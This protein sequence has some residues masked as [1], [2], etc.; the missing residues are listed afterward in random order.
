MMDELRLDL[1]ERVP[2]LGTQTQF[3]SKEGCKRGGALSMTR[4]Q[5]CGWGLLEIGVHL[6]GQK[7]V[8]R[9]A[10]VQRA[11]V[12][13]GAH[14]E[15]RPNGFSSVDRIE[16]GFRRDDG[17]GV[18]DS[19]L[20]AR[21]AFERSFKEGGPIPCLEATAVLTVTLTTAPV[22]V[23]HIGSGRGAPTLGQRWRNRVGC[24]TFRG[25]PRAVTR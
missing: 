20:V 13:G 2:S 21:Q 7:V 1:F 4:L 8:L 25:F 3:G 9:F 6:A 22:R 14:T 11:A 18:D 15:G 23:R 5:A 12:G 16:A 19:E 10:D 17:G 24:S